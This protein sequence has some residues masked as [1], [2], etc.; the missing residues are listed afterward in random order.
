MAGLTAGIGT[1][2]KEIMHDGTFYVTD[3]STDQVSCVV[4]TRE[5]APIDAF[6][7]RA[8]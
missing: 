3:Q 2:V 4:E 6:K 8:R 1:T 7:I 5:Q